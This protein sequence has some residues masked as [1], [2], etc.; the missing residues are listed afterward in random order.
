ME[1]SSSV[2]QPFGREASRISVAFAGAFTVE[3]PFLSMR[4]CELQQ[5]KRGHHSDCDE[6]HDVGQFD[7]NAVINALEPAGCE[8]LLEEAADAAGTIPAALN[9]HETAGAHLTNGPGGDH[10]GVS[11]G[12]DER[13]GLRLG[14][15][16]GDGTDPLRRR[17]QLPTRLRARADTALDHLVVAELPSEDRRTALGVV[18]D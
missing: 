9:P 5:A 8:L 13:A 18:R 16:D 14:D 11:I 2:G 4:F 7:Q 17:L 3:L 1:K 10:A 6:L 12:L 15:G